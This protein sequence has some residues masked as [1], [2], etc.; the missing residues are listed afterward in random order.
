MIVRL[1]E[2]AI[3]VVVVSL[4]IVGIAIAKGFWMTLGSFFLPPM[5]LV[6]FAQWLLERL[7]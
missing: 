2:M 7:G 6:I 5:A 1:A 3:G 4:W